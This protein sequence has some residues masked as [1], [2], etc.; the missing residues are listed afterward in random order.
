MK[1]FNRAIDKFC[2][3]HPRFGIP[4][5]MLLVVIGSAAVYIISMMDRTGTFASYLMFS[6]AH[7]LRGQVWRLV[8]FVF[9]PQFGGLI[10]TAIG[11]YFYYFIGSTLQR[12]WGAGRFTLYYLCGIVF[13]LIYGFIYYFIT[14]YTPYLDPM[15][16][17]F[18]MFFAFALLFPETRVLLFFFIPIKIKYLGLIMAAFF[19]YWIVRGNLLPIVAVINLLLFC[20]EYIAGLFKR[21]AKT[22]ASS[23]AF[24]QK[25]RTARAAVNQNSYTHKCAVCGRTDTEYP[26][27][28]FRYCSKCA[29]YRCF[30]IDHINSHVHF[31]SED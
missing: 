15:Y 16:L 18:S 20:G 22:R 4:N 19:V 25:M 23:N 1:S 17:N 12:E 8:T 2:W 29:G 6:P 5:L 24:K 28:D 13:Y 21:S 3:R 11:L 26:D 27:L 7:I 10:W 31:T 30:C 9:I 14:G